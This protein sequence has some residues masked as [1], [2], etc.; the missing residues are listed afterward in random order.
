M[1]RG[2]Q[3]ARWFALLEDLKATRLGVPVE[4]LAERHGWAPRT[5]YRDLHGLELAGF[6]VIR[7]E[8]G[9]WKLIDGWERTLLFP[10]PP[11]ERLALQVA[12]EF[13]APLRRTP[14][15]AAFERLYDRLVGPS[16]PF[17]ARSRQ[18]ELFR[19]LRPLLV[20]RSALA[21]DYTEHQATL[22][23]LCRAMDRGRTLRARYLVRSRDELTVRKIDPYELY[24]D[25]GLE[26]LYL[27]AY[28]HLRGE[29]RTFAVHRFRQLVET[30]GCYVVPPDFS[31][32]SY[33]GQA[34]RIWREKNAVRVRIAVDPPDAGWVAERRWHASQEVVRRAG[35]GCEL[36]FLVDGTREISRFVLQLGASAEVLEPDSLRRQIAREHARAARRSAGPTQESLTLDDNSRTETDDRGGRRGGRKRIGRRAQAAIG[37]TGLP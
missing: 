32:A 15:G 13:V 18:G 17:S 28:C 30:N 21:I 34:F 5:V 19:R 12:R 37:K 3:V 4:R 33:L 31:A 2:A 35:G 6:P 8:G 9:R 14:A 11:D 10:L 36:R 1:P 16:S 29:V 25:P 26:A 7:C 24:W 22:A 20:A 27:F 23:T